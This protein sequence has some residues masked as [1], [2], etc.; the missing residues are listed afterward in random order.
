MN[1]K[2]NHS[3]EAVDSLYRKQKRIMGIKRRG[4]SFG[5]QSDGLFYHPKKLD[6]IPIRH[7]NNKKD[8]LVHELSKQDE[9]IKT[10]GQDLPKKKYQ[11]IHADL[12]KL[13]RSTTGEPTTSNN[14]GAESPSRVGSSSA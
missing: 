13:L 9:M 7:G 14:L 12:E 6:I 10:Q 3:E 8:K 4:Y 2:M 11:L 1:S 5:R